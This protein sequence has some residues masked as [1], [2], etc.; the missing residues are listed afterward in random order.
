[1]ALSVKAYFYKPDGNTEIRRFSIDQ[2]VTTS[3]EYLLHKVRDVFPGLQD[4]RLTFYWADKEGDTVAFSSDEELL[5]ALSEVQDGVFK[6]SIEVAGDLSNSMFKGVPHPGVVCD[7][8][9][10]PVVGIRY[11][12]VQCPDYDLCMNC[13]NAGKHP[14]H[15]MIRMVKPRPIFTRGPCGI[16]G[17]R[18]FRVIGP[19]VMGPCGPIMMRR[20]VHNLMK[21]NEKKEENS[22]EKNGTRKEENK[23]EPTPSTSAGKSSE[24]SAKKTKPGTA[25]DQGKACGD[26]RKE[27]EALLRN[28]GGELASMLVPF[29][30]EMDIDVSDDDENTDKKNGNTSDKKTTADKKSPENEKTDEKKSPEEEKTDDED[31]RKDPKPTDSLTEGLCSTPEETH[32]AAVKPSNEKQVDQSQTESSDWTMIEQATPSAQPKTDINSGATPSVPTYT[33]ATKSSKSSSYQSSS[34]AGA[35]LYPV[36]SE[37]QEPLHHDPR[38]NKSLQQMM[39]MGFS[40]EGG[41][42]VRLLESKDG[43]ISKVL[44]AIQPRRY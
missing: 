10:G 19:Q 18:S 21:E 26:N 37:E 16:G 7:A 20:F 41:W 44:D 8:C 5:S 2:D 14:E 12:C 28:L 23:Q 35:S 1:M 43:N 27:L 39:S 11:K 32:E 42:L 13:E 34:S 4:K 36:I 31:G 25:H 9:D 29:G 24:S 33:E 22:T 15:R 38:V 3:F 30:V 40:N 17:P 6:M